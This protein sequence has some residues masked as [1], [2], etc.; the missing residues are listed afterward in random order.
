MLLRTQMPPGRKRHSWLCPR[1][2]QGDWLP[3]CSNTDTVGLKVN[4]NTDLLDF[5]CDLPEQMV[6][7]FLMQCGVCCCHAWCTKQGCFGQY[8]KEPSHIL[9]IAMCSQLFCCCAADFGCSHL[10]WCGCLC[11]STHWGAHPGSRCFC[12]HRSVHPIAMFFMSLRGHGEWL[13]KNPEFSVVVNQ[14]AQYCFQP[15]N[16]RPDCNSQTRYNRTMPEPL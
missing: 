8:C 12:Q 7:H 10:Q 15:N 2:S 6:K 3:T 16:V 1:G 4:C 11:C 9:N 13:K 14:S 5:G